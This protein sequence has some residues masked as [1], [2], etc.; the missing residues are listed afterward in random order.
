MSA[1][2]LELSLRIKADLQQATDE[3]A[4]LRN[5]MLK[6]GETAR[7]SSADFRV[8]ADA[9]SALLA[10]ISPA[11]AALQRLD[12]LE[13]QLNAHMRAGTID[14]EKYNIAI[15][16]I[17]A[18]RNGF[19]EITAEGGKAAKAVEGL[20]VSS[21]LATREV[22]TLGREAARGNFTRMAG[23]ATILAQA[24]GLEFTPALL[25]AGAAITAVLI[26]VAALTVA[27]AQG[28]LE[29]Q[30]FNREIAATGGIAGV[31]AGQLGEMVDTV[32][33]ATGSFGK[34]NDAIDALVESGKITGSALQAVAEAAVNLSELTGKSIKQTT[35]EVEGLGESPAATLAKL[36]E[37]YHFLTQSTY[38]QVRALEDQG[39]TEEAEN[40]AAATIANATKQ[41]LDDVRTHLG[42]LERGWDAVK[43]AASGAWQAMKDAG[44]TDLDFRLS[45][46]RDKLTDLKTPGIG[47][48]N[49][50]SSATHAQ[51]IVAAQ[52]VVNQLEAESAAADK[53]AKSHAALQAQQDKGV[54]ADAGAADE[55][56]KLKEKGLLIGKNTELEQLNARIAAGDYK[57]TSAALIEQLRAQ[58]AI[59]DAEKAAADAKKKKPKSTLGVDRAELAADVG[60]VRDSLTALNDAY[61]NSEKVL[62]AQHKAGKVSDADYYKQKLDHINTLEAGEVAALNQEIATLQQHR[63]SGAERIRIDREVAQVQTQLAKVQADAD[64]KRTELE[65]QQ[66][67]KLQKAAEDAQ[68]AYQKVIDELRTPVEANL[69][70]A[71]EQ[72]DTLNTSLEKGITDAANYKLQLQRAFDAAFTDAPDIKGPKASSGADQ[73]TKERTALEDWYNEQIALLNGF[74]QRKEGTEAIWNAKEEQIE[75]K[76]QEA[77]RQLEQTRQQLILA[78]AS[79]FFGNLAS[80]QHSGN[81]KMA[82]IG[83][84]AAIAQ[85]LINTYQAATAA[86]ASLASIP[87][88]GPALGAAAAAAAIIAGLANVAQIRAQQTTFDAGGYTGAGGKY[89]PAGV[90][91][92]G[93]YVMPQES[94]NRYGL[95]FMQAVH[96]GTMPHYETARAP[97]AMP[98]PRYSLA[99][100]GLASGALDLT[101]QL[102]MRLINLF[103]IDDIARRVAASPHIERTVINTIGNNPHAVRTALA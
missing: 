4:K 90:V 39:R 67:A 36:N 8:Q 70:K 41:R 33:Q 56:A 6:T 69:Q 65:A 88:I 57:N 9:V 22:L 43:S 17:S 29:D 47:F 27:M 25:L 45:Q 64:A 35:A 58:A 32:G 87:Y 103:D 84:A 26:P 12:I 95:G 1:G 96:A 74:R 92:R 54:K 34:A 89:D 31:T 72:I 91:H 86:Y 76:H 82:A 83:K 28:Y 77:L 38:D 19:A 18:Q 100:G 93:E 48:E 75:A 63:A 49:F 21:S 62:D 98:A 16:Q 11:E 44:R 53:A 30:R 23:S 85:A 71:K 46:A 51:N 101:P 37:S 61:S 66:D 102:N 68:R 5:E 42:S 3:V 20:G 94:V 15:G 24:L 97:L 80:L 78:G 13:T 10:K 59:N 50:F 55:L 73:Y 2:N 79:Q 7:T 81:S 52:A 99:E 40:L 60:A 14:A